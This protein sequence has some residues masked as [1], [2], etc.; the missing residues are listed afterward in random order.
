MPRIW[1]S[2]FAISRWILAKRRT[3]FYTERSAT[4]HNCYDNLKEKR[5]KPR[6][7]K[8]TLTLPFYEL[9]C[10]EPNASGAF[11]LFVAF[12]QWRLACLIPPRAAH[13]FRPSLAMPH[14]AVAIICLCHPGTPP[15]RRPN[16]RRRKGWF[17]AAATDLDEFARA[18]S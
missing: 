12:N 5:R 18:D 7:E 15:R 17:E 3:V 10:L 14:M 9:F 16:G 4:M 2:F 8:L 6:G 1:E 11:G 13:P